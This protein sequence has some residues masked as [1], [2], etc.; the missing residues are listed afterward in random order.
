MG[1]GG[2]AAR[3][4]S[5]GPTPR[6]PGG[7]R[8]PL[9]AGAG[10]SPGGRGR[11]RGL[12]DSLDLARRR[13]AA[14]LLP[15]SH[16]LRPPRS[17]LVSSLSDAVAVPQDEPVAR[18]A[19][20]PGLRA[21][22]STFPL[23]AG[24]DTAEWAYDR[25][26][27]RPRVAHGARRSLESWP[28]ARR[29]ASP[30]TATWARF[31]LPGRY[32]VDGVSVERAAG[33]RAA[34]RCA[35]L[36]LVRR[37]RADARPSRSC[38]RLP[39]RRARASARWRPRRRGAAVRAAGERRA[40][41]GSWQRLRRARR[42]RRGAARP[43]C[44]RRAPALDPRREAL[45]DRGRRARAS[46]CPTGRRASAADV[47]RALEPETDRGPRRGAGPAG[48]GESWDPGWAAAAR[49]RGP[50]ASCA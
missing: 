21:A 5:S 1:A 17:A 28:G 14:P 4:R 25:A 33:S 30:A 40:A 43:R 39:E 44:R 9:G 47:V 18:V 50:R 34:H 20:A 12:G 26:D 7:A 46:R 38:R 31:A 16:R 8:S 11:R 35:R 19:R 42:R 13:R 24:V 48:R 23:R 6:A 10:L 22:S 2:H 45:A 49:R 32:F 37:A 29:G 3:R 36:A 27:V 41:R 15:A